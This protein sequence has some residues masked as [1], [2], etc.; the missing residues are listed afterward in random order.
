MRDTDFRYALDQIVL[1]VGAPE[2]QEWEVFL[3]SGKRPR[4]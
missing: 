4:L 2:D 3:A 1:D